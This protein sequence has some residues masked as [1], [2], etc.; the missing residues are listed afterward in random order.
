MLDASTMLDARASPTDQPTASQGCSLQRR[1][2]RARRVT[3]L[4]PAASQGCS[5]ERQEACHPM[6]RGEGP[7]SPIRGP[8]P[9]RP[10]LRNSGID[11]GVFRPFT[12]NPNFWHDHNHDHFLGAPSKPSVF[13]KTGEFLIHRSQVRIL[14]GVLRFPAFSL[15]FAGRALHAKCRS[16]VT[17]RQH[18]DFGTTRIT[19][20][21]EGL[22]S[23]QWL[24]SRHLASGGRRC[25][26]SV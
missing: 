5:V 20:I 15:V 6:G 4:Q 7:N 8:R 25:P 16:C 24:K 13:A 2:A 3:R 26:A 22:Q 17:T 21:F 12:E 11:Y 18:R 1:H 9:S 23:D 10:R 14:P 19:T